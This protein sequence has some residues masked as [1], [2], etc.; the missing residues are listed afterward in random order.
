MF[1]ISA[2]HFGVRLLFFG[3]LAALNKWIQSQQIQSIRFT[4]QIK[5]LPKSFF[6]Q[7]PYFAKETCLWH[8]NFI[9]IMVLFYINWLIYSVLTF[10][11]V[12]HLYK[13]TFRQ[14]HLQFNNAGTSEPWIFWYCCG[15]SW[16]LCRLA[17]ERWDIAPMNITQLKYFIEVVKQKSFTK[18]AEYFFVS[19]STISKSVRSLEKE[20]NV[21]LIDRRSKNAHLTPEGN[22]FYQSATKIIENY[23]NETL[24]LQNALI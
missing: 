13:Y 14:Q 3:S 11:H 19:E 4:L 23:T 2:L 1:C 5:E 17:L 15:Y 24:K 22:V 8:G 7:I 6:V 9:K 12:L 20:Y 10:C 18:A 21:Q 16:L